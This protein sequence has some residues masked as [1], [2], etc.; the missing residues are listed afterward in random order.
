[1]HNS[2]KYFSFRFAINLH[3]DDTE[4]LEFIKE[5][6]SV[7]KVYRSGNLSSCKERRGYKNYNK[8]F[9]GVSIEYTQ[10]SKFLSF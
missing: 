9:Y 10:A 5:R 4:T 8:K 3:V 2:G 1:M 7:G 6:L